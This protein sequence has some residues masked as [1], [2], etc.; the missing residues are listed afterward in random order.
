MPIITKRLLDG[1]KP[2]GKLRILPDDELIGFGA[3]ITPAGRISFCVTYR[4]AGKQ[5]RR[6]IGRASAP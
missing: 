1:I 4:F 5:K 2:D 6:V 3:Q